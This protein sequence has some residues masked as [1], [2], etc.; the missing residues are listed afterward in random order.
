MGALGVWRRCAAAPRPAAPC[1]PSM[2]HSLSAPQTPPLGLAFSNQIQ[3][4]VLIRSFFD[5]LDA[6]A[7]G[8]DELRDEVA[9]TRHQGRHGDGGA[10]GLCALDDMT[11]A[12]NDEGDGILI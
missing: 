10:V 8:I 11:D 9:V 12:S 7:G 4:L 1:L 2:P 5:Q 6:V 3:V